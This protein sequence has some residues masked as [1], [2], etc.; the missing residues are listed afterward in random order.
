LDRP[1]HPLFHGRAIRRERDAAVDER[2]EVR[3]ALTEA[4]DRPAGGT[5]RPRHALE[6]DQEPRGHPGNEPEVLALDPFGHGVDP[7][8]PVRDR[9][10]LAPGRVPRAESRWQILDHEPREIADPAALSD[11]LQAR[12]STE[13][14]ERPARDALEPGAL[15]RD[16]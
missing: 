12:A 5:A 14:Q 10:D 7:L 1:A 4:R 3:P 2:A 13:E 15:R 8:I 9:G 16:Q 11:R 6:Q